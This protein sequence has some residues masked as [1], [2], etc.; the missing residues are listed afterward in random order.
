MQQ[1]E[2]LKTSRFFYSDRL[3]DT[4]NSLIIL[5]I[6]TLHRRN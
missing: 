6:L 4:A 2:M 3:L 1:G 5:N